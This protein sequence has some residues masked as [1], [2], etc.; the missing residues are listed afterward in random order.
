MHPH[1][2]RSSGP[3]AWG[4][5]R[6]SSGL[7]GS[8]PPLAGAWSLCLAVL[9][10]TL[11]V[12]A[13]VPVY[14]T[15]RADLHRVYTDGYFED[16]DGVPVAWTDGI[17]DGGP[18]GVDFDRLWL[19][20]D[21]DY[22]YIRFE[23][24]GEVLLQEDNQLTLMIDTDQNSGTGYPFPGL[25]ADLIWEFGERQGFFFY[26]TEYTNIDWPVL[27]LAVGPT[28]S[29]TQFEVALLKEAMVG[30]FPCFPQDE[31][32]LQLRDQAGGGDWIPNVGTVVEYTM[33]VGSLEPMPTIELARD[34][35]PVRLITYNVYQDRLWNG[36]AIPSYERILQA[37][38][39]DVIAFQE[40]YDHDANET[41]EVVA[42]WLG[43]GWDAAQVSDKVLL[44]RGDILGVWSIAGGRAGAFL[45]GPVANVDEDF[46]VINCHLNCCGADEE[47]QEQCDAIMQFVRDAKT[48]GGLIDLTPDNPI[49]ITGD[50]NFVGLKRQLETLLTGD[51]EDEA[52]YGP[53][54]A[55]D[56]DGT[57]F[58]DLGSHLC[59]GPMG[60]T[61]YKEWSDYGPGRLD[62]II[63][64]DSNLSLPVH[65]IL[66]TTHAPGSFLNEYGLYAGDSEE[67]SDH[68]PH[69][70]DFELVQQ[71]I[72]PHWATFEE[73]LRL[74]LAGG[75]P[76]RGT[77]ELW[78]RWNASAGP[79][80]GEDAR[81]QVIDA[82]GRSLRRLLP[83][84]ED[85]ASLRF[86]WDGRD[87]AGRVVSP[88]LYW[89]RAA[90]GDFRA[91][92]PVMWIR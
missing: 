46:L 47:R 25:G 86:V 80:V 6:C 62:F 29:G 18:N 9:L 54:F 35:G 10:V 66:Q 33:E 8:V 28:H 38:D 16:W 56:W 68:L 50:M 49:L 36:Y 64:S 67:A 51:I 37:L 87:D 61:W 41:R 70:T 39:P 63:Y 75:N 45:C 5:S 7:L 24:T 44:T 77:L 11:L 27:R 2:H 60:Y 26:G 78:L 32:Y 57:D 76:A 34:P 88:G 40:I 83:R 20:D 59:T 23:T 73:P 79:A 42:G 19:A 72:E 48:P 43:A 91:S 69:F 21:E 84:G 90:A 82:T 14:S 55:P 58:T 85:D 13:L 31:V 71:S 12:P 65:G 92:R 74:H 81:V 53:D 1:F 15:A 22:L 17:G 3:W 89:L 4:R 52:T 30:G